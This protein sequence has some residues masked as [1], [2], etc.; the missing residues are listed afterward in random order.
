M[1]R[2]FE[3]VMHWE[4]GVQFQ[5][6]VSQNT[7]AALVGCETVHRWVGIPICAER[8]ADKLQAGSKKEADL[9][10]LFISCTGMRW[11]II[12]EMSTLSPGLLGTLDAY[13]H[14]ACKRFPFAVQGEERWPFGGIS[15]F[16]RA[17]YGSCLRCR[18]AASSATLI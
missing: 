7:M 12:D 18:P 3:E 8:A 1:Q 16:L 14:R 13:L 11:I 5:C 2:F 10:A 4:A 6:L 9:D 15:I 17:T